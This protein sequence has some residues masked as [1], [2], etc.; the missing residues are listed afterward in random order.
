MWTTAIAL[1]LTLAQPGPEWTLA[2]GGDIM[3][4]GI[5]PSADPLGEIGS[6]FQEADVA[7]ANLE[8][9]L[10]TSR[11]PTRAKS[12]AEVKARTQ[13]ILKADPGH[14]P[15]FKSAGFDLLSLANNHGMDYGWQGLK[16]TMDLVT[17]QGIAHSGGGD[18]REAA[19]QPAVMRLKNGYRVGMISALAFV[20][21]GALA[22]CG[23]ATDSKP[24]IAVFQFNGVINDAAKTELQR[25]IANAKRRCDFLIVAPHWG[26]EKASSPREWQIK[27]G[28]AIVDAGADAVIGAHPHVLQ[29]RE[30]YRGK[31]ILYSTGNLVSAMPANSAVYS[32]TFKGAKLTGWDLRPF[33]IRG[34][35]SRWLKPE[36]EAAVKKNILALDRLIPAPRKSAASKAAAD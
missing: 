10:T 9:P 33:E 25:R 30:I 34:G 31:P 18:N 23:P 6:F 28:R 3:L 2:A 24:G 11:T 12:A 35:R 27:L 15:S 32:L 1:T 36:R 22:K 21:S 19:N 8:I 26:V 7:Y 14:A 29:G 20:G 17:G 4:N 5:R 16:E 13:F